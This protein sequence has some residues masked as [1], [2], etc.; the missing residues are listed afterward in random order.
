MPLVEPCVY[1]DEV[2]DRVKDQFVMVS[3][4]TTAT[5]EKIAHLSCKQKRR[6]KEVGFKLVGGQIRSSF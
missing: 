4:V 3:P 2:I 6:G 1:C 5:C